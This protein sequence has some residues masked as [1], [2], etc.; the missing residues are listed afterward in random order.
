MSERA[1]DRW[2][3]RAESDVDHQVNVFVHAHCSHLSD[4]TARV[5]RT[6]E[7]RPEKAERAWRTWVVLL[8]RASTLA[9]GCRPRAAALM[10]EA[11]AGGVPALSKLARD[12][13]HCGVRY[14]GHGTG[15]GTAL[16]PPAAPVCPTVAHAR[17][18]D[19]MEATDSEK[20]E[21]WTDSQTFIQACNSGGPVVP[22]T[23]GH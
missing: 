11:A 21:Q 13:N 6:R 17:A 8:S 12:C 2:D 14:G 22:A 9:C 16:P 1:L 15:T 5:G 20:T 19:R 18:H 7:R 23:R 10:G 3:D 4:I